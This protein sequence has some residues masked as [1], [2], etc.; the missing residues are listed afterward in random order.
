MTRVLAAIAFVLVTSGFVSAQT[1]GNAADMSRAYLCS[2]ISGSNMAAPTWKS[3]PDGASEQQVLIHYKGS[4]ELS[5]ATWV[6]GGT[7]YYEARGLGMPMRSGFSIGVFAE[8]LAEMYVFNAGTSELF[9]TSIRSGSALLPNLMK[10]F[11]ATCKPAGALA[12]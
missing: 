9:Y 3:E 8:E 12:R 2:N 6:K 7:P 4:L 1:N 10:S 11:K 5:E